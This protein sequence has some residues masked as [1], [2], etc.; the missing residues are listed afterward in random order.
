MKPGDPVLSEVQMTRAATTLIGSMALFGLIGII[1]VWLVAADDLR[2]GYHIVPVLLLASVAAVAAVGIPHVPGLVTVRRLPAGLALA[3][4]GIAAACWFSGPV[5]GP[6]VAMSFLCV[7]MFAS[8]FLTRA[9][10]LAVIGWVG[11]LYG[12]V[13]AFQSGNRGPVTR[14]VLV[15]GAVMVSALL[16]GALADRIH[17]LVDSERILRLEVEEASARLEEATRHRR[18]FLAGMSH[19][20]RTPLN[21][22]IGFA[23]ILTEGLFG[24]LSEAQRTLVQTIRASGGRLLALVGEVL[25]LDAGDAESPPH[26]VDLPTTERG[27]LMRADPRA[28]LAYFL[29][30]P[31]A[32]GTLPSFPHDMH[33]AAV[34]AIAV[35]GVS[36][37]MAVLLNRRIDPAT[38]AAAHNI[39]VTVVAAAEAISG[40]SMISPFATLAFVWMATAASIRLTPR[41]AAVQ[42]VIIAVCEAI[43]V[44]VQAGNV[45]PV[46]RWEITTA[47]ACT[48]AVVMRMVVNRLFDAAELEAASRQAADD[49]RSALE[50]ANRHKVEFLQNVRHELRWPADEVASAAAALLD[51]RSDALSPKQAEY[52]RDIAGAGDQLWSLITDI[53]DL[54]T[55][56]AGGMTID[57]AD[58]ALVDLLHDAVADYERPAAAAG[59][60]LQL[61]VEPVG[62]RVWADRDKLVR[63]VAGLVSNAVKFTPSG[64]RVRV[65]ARI[66]AHHMTIAV[67]DTGRGIPLEDHSRI[68]EGFQ[69]GRSAMVAPGVGLGLTLARRF[70]E[71]QGGE[72]ELQSEPGVG[73]TFTITLPVFER[74]TSARQEAPVA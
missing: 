42:I 63:A 73:S 51:G 49:T 74:P 33:F 10:S 18:E 46:F 14:W 72:V 61:D 34:V 59:V 3:A 27:P 57:V 55:L 54:A 25:A 24:P 8:L 40:G 11:L 52:A 67:A 62:A 6:F 53:L 69:Q 36:L 23:D 30:I 47:T 39:L 70:V 29:L 21:A 45:A 26:G 16:V 20:L 66:D 58:V 38:Q 12:L 48:S 60:V 13:L 5:F 9:T 17:Q 43:V 56:E 35:A 28:A 64:G 2:P 32:L 41:V 50:A 44:S 15:M 37:D 71:L 65:R 22:I 19:E 68:F 31:V 1:G 7:G 4:A